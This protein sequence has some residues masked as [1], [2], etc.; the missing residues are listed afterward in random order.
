MSKSDWIKPLIFGITSI[1]LIALWA[2]YY[3]GSEIGKARGER[4]YHSASYEQHARDEI[5]DTCLTGEGVDIAECVSKVIQATNENTRAEDDRIAQSEMARWAAYMLVATVIMAVIT[6]AGVVLVWLTLRSTA[7]GLDIMRD[8]QRPLISPKLCRVE[9]S[10]GRG[11][12]VYFEWENLG[13]GPA[14]VV[15]MGQMKSN[16]FNTIGVE[17]F[18]DTHNNK[19]S[20]N[21]TSKII[22]T[23][24]C[25]DHNVSLIMHEYFEVANNTNM[26]GEVF[27][28]FKI[29][30]QSLFFP[31]KT[32]STS[33]IVQFF[34]IIFSAEGV[35]VRIAGNVL[36]RQSDVVDYVGVIIERETT[37][38]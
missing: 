20:M 15:S 14:R 11:R 8:E 17:G 10:N 34:P 16:F 37:Y 36:P 35:K 7:D 13:N 22:P 19:I 27:I 28:F 5:R 32:F 26:M 12:H 3:V 21:V 24:K 18:K 4:N 38:D 29:E 6:G 25:F 2:A 9:A 30:Y 1:A 31:S 23:G 33:G